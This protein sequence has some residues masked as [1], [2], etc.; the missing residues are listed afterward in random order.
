M[1]ANRPWCAIAQYPGLKSFHVGTVD[2]PHDAQF[3]EIEQ[4]LITHALTFLP[5]GFTIIQPKCGAL[6]FQ[7]FEA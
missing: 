1:T 3:Y 4:A 5:E 6:F 2:M 7:E